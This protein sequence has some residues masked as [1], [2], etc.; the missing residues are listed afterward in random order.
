[1]SDYILK[2]NWE[3]NIFRNQ[4]IEI[5]RRKRGKKYT[6][7]TLMIFFIY[8]FF[9]VSILKERLTIALL[10]SILVPILIFLTLL[11][12]QIFKE[13]KEIIEIYTNRMILK[14]YFLNYNF[15]QKEVLF[16]EIK[17]IFFEKNIESDII[18]D[19]FCFEADI[20]KNLKIRVRYKEYEDKIYTYGFF[21]KKEEYNFIKNIFEDTHLKENF[22]N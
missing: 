20:L 21:L 12:L 4:I 7:L 14:R 2:N 3:I 10:N 16:D 5:N 15:S 11:L 13:S 19:F 18:T 22:K 1:M 9:I 6:F 17:E 8:I